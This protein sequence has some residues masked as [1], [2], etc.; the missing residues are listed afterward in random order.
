MGRRR[1][2]GR[3]REHLYYK[4]AFVDGMLSVEPQERARE[5]MSADT[6]FT[7]VF[8]KVFKALCTILSA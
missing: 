3:G 6:V 1:P 2:F 4:R 8:T 5:R 7:E